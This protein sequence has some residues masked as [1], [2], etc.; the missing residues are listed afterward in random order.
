MV[1]TYRCSRSSALAHMY[2][3]GARGELSWNLLIRSANVLLPLHEQG[4]R[5]NVVSTPE[6][7]ATL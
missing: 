3:V 5:S 1:A 2:R 4:I 7:P 6:T